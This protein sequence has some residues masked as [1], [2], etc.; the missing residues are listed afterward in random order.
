MV[1]YFVAGRNMLMVEHA[2]LLAMARPAPSR[3]MQFLSGMAN[4]FS[5][6]HGSMADAA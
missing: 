5:M 6:A 1:L 4:I 3:G 2:L